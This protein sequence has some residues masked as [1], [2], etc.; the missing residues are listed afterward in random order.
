M[1]TTIPK[2]PVACLELTVADAFRAILDLRRAPQACFLM[3]LGAQAAWWLGLPQGM[4]YLPLLCMLCTACWGVFC[5]RLAEQLCPLEGGFTGLARTL[6]QDGG[7]RPPRWG[8]L[9]GGASVLGV[10][11]ALPWWPASLL[12]TAL[13]AI[14]VFYP[15]RGRAAVVAVGLGAAAI[16]VAVLL[17]GCVATSPVTRLNVG[18]GAL[19]LL[20]LLIAG[21]DALL[22]SGSWFRAPLRYAWGLPAVLPLLM[23]HWHSLQV[24]VPLYLLGLLFV[25]AALV[26]VSVDR[27]H[28][29]LTRCED[30]IGRHGFERPIIGK[31]AS[32]LREDVV[33]DSDDYFRVCHPEFRHWLAARTGDNG[34]LAWV[35]GTDDRT[36]PED[37]IA[38][39]TTNLAASPLTETQDRCGQAMAALVQKLLP[40]LKPRALEPLLKAFRD[41]WS[42]RRLTQQEPL[43]KMPWDHPAMVV[44]PVCWSGCFIYPA[45]S[46][47]HDQ[48]GYPCRARKVEVSLC[49]RSEV[50]DAV[51][52]VSASPR[53]ASVQDLRLCRL[54]LWNARRILPGAYES[55][56]TCLVRLFRHETVALFVELEAS[57]EAGNGFALGAGAQEDFRLR[58]NEAWA[59]ALP[60]PLRE[61]IDAHVAE[62]N[63]DTYYE[64]AALTLQLELR[65]KQRSHPF[66]LKKD[67]NEIGKMINNFVH[68][69][70]LVSRKD[71]NGED[72]DEVVSVR[73]NLVED[74]AQAHHKIDKAA[75]AA[76]NMINELRRNTE[77][78]NP[79]RIASMYGPV[80]AKMRESHLAFEAKVTRWFREIDEALRN[81]PDL[82]AFSNDE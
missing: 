56:L 12:W 44:I 58:L 9:L 35:G 41:T 64:S 69:G 21:A 13:V 19:L 43:A 8:V 51:K 33:R 7:F 2:K 70:E 82:S 61:L 31:D 18:C 45:G 15:R 60:S 75:T 47:I 62:L 72:V 76:H 4:W 11:L 71:A 17:L 24:V 27:H 57:A 3:V 23:L 10:A 5:W 67:L 52:R 53:A 49:L 6:A 37:C 22:L 55:L 66:Q 14:T 78:V 25:P 20:T 34:Y 50:L 42:V 30:L 79:D 40:N 48:D 63:I 28:R 36:L 29:A 54:L 68:R 81:L 39:R 80:Q 74:V 16:G 26:I 1:S 77:K 59:D 46:G 73:F 38:F 32:G 65:H